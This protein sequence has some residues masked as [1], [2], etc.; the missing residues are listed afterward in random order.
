MQITVSFYARADEFRAWL[1]TY[2]HISSLHFAL[3]GGRPYR[4][5]PLASFQQLSAEECVVW[6]EL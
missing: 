2:P 4:I 3:A 1:A 5:A 6:R